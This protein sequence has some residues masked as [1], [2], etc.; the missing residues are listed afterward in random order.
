M[1]RKRKILG[2]LWYTFLWY[3]VLLLPFCNLITT[4]VPDILRQIGIC[5]GSIWN[6]QDFKNI[7]QILNLY[8]YNK[9]YLFMPRFCNS[10]S[11]SWSYLK[12]IV[13]CTNC[14]LKLIPF[15][16]ALASKFSY[17]ALVIFLNGI[18]S[19]NERLKK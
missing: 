18:W 16:N 4:W 3:A 1:P 19:P 17:C 11:S 6:T 9:Y 2:R 12:S 15:S 10:W 14:S 8:C 5:H 13:S 7:Y